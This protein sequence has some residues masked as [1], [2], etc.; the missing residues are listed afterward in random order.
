MLSARR[1]EDCRQ[2]LDI[3]RS[4]VAEPQADIEPG[5]PSVTQL[6]SPDDVCPTPNRGAVRQENFKVEAA[7]DRE[8]LIRKDPHPP[9]AD[10]LRVAFVV[11]ERRPGGPA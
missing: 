11:K 2:P 10:V 7:A 4:H 9:E 3:G 1:D 6:S 8:V 5:W